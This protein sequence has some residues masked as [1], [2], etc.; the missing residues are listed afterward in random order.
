MANVLRSG[1][2]PGEIA[3]HPLGPS[4]ALQAGQR[5][6]D[7]PEPKGPVVAESFVVAGFELVPVRGTRFEQAQ[8][9]MRNADMPTPY[10][11]GIPAMYIGE[12]RIADVLPPEVP[13][14]CAASSPGMRWLA[15]MASATNPASGDDGQGK[16]DARLPKSGLS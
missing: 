14:S 4:L 8:E 6:V 3:A 10:Q 13:L 5:G 2:A 15:A 9:H 11:P 12:P 16:G 7:L 1:P